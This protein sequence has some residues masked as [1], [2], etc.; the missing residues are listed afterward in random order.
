M[1]EVTLIRTTDS[2]ELT[3]VDAVIM[4]WLRSRIYLVDHVAENKR[5]TTV[6]PK[7]MLLLYWYAQRNHSV[8]VRRRGISI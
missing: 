1:N 5:R 7:G 4:E 6:G 3:N 8:V 2:F